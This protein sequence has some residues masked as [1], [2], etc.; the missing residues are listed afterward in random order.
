MF[1]GQVSE[2]I[3]NTSK[4]SLYHNCCFNP[5]FNNINPEPIFKNLQDLAI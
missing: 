1:A 3:R 5:S 4:H 2:K